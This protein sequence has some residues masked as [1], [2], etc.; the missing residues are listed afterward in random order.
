MKRIILTSILLSGLLSGFAQGLICPATFQK[1][2]NSGLWAAEVFGG[3]KD[4]RGWAVGGGLAY[5]LPRFKSGESPAK[6]LFPNKFIRVDGFY[7]N[8]RF[9]K[10]LHQASGI[11]VILGY[12]PFSVGD[13]FYGSLL[14]GG[15]Y[16]ND[17]VSPYSGPVNFK[18]EL[19]VNKA[20]VLFGVEVSAF[21]SRNGSLSVI[22]SFTQRSLVDEYWGTWR[23]YASLGLRFHF[24]TM[25]PL[26]GEKKRN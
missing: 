1:Y 14:A 9:R 24:I 17:K 16:S 20:G 26:S 19:S 4:W 6:Y 23:W 18:E 3:P 21:L 11:D 10:I 8:D 25:R 5:F 12:T 22:G 2:K 13:V 15:S 7:S